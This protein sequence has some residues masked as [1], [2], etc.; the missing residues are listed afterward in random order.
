MKMRNLK[1]LYEEQ[2]NFSPS[3]EA[4]VFFL[5]SPYLEND[6][7]SDFLNY[8]KN[9]TSVR[10]N[11]TDDNWFALAQAT[12]IHQNEEKLIQLSLKAK[13]DSANASRWVITGARAPF[14]NV[15]H[16]NNNTF[17][18]S[19]S[20]ELNFID[21]YKVFQDKGN[22]FSYSDDTFH[23][24]SLTLLLQSINRGEME[25]KG[26]FELKFYFLQ[27]DGWLV[28]VENHNHLGLSGGWM[29]SSLQKADMAQKEKFISNSLFI[30]Y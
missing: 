15:S 14:L 29:I 9:D 19:T 27:L 17:I 23:G 28:E 4:S 21:L 10:L 30:N 12:V 11:F 1:N 2:R 22:A 25:F 18:P 6:Y 8:I 26:V 24:D 13:T 3:Q 20:N 16:Q 5:F 7:K